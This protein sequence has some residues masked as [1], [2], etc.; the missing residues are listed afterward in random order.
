M[1]IAP[2][3]YSSS[4]HKKVFGHFDYRT[5][6]QIKNEIVAS[7]LK[8]ESKDSQFRDKL[9]MQ[10]LKELQDIDEYLRTLFTK[11]LSI[12]DRIEILECIMDSSQSDWPRIRTEGEKKSEIK[13]KYIDELSYPDSVY[14]GIES[15]CASNYEKLLHDLPFE[16][17]ESLYF[18]LKQLFTTEC[19]NGERDKIVR[20]LL[21]I[22]IEDWAVILAQVCEIMPFG[23]RGHDVA[24]AVEILAS[25]VN[26]N[27]REKLVSVAMR[28]FDC[29]TNT[30]T[31][32]YLLSALSRLDS[33]KLT[34]LDLAKPETRENFITTYVPE[35]VRSYIPAFKN[36]K[37]RSK[38]RW[39]IPG[40]A[41]FEGH[42]G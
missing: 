35:A 37:G 9:L 31:R 21:E 7:L 26:S 8:T 19:L 15:N 42:V 23:S 5:E 32:G 14:H 12:H 17:V 3:D 2:F 29:Q 41:S 13:L 10:P 1:F 11:V 30:L 28:L 27:F 4:A 36:E 22:N 18:H 16:S 20:N 6:K 34:E 40:I 33:Q 39:N 25:V 24:W 38:K